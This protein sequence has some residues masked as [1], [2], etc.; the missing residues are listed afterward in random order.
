MGEVAKKCCGMCPFA[1]DGTLGLH[2]ERAE[3]FAVMATNPYNDF[4]CHKT[5]ETDED[6]YGDGEAAIVRGENSRTCHG[7]RTLQM[8][9]NDGEVFD[10]EDESN[11]PDGKGFECEYEMVERHEELWE[12]GSA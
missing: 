7:F 5:G 1:R 2:P 9:S 3:E 12:R 6:F 4:V 8:A 11:K 10:Y